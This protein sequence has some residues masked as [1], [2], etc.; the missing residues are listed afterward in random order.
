MDA[1]APTRLARSVGRSA[2]IVVDTNELW[3]FAESLR[4]AHRDLEASPT[5]ARLDAGDT[6]GRLPDAVSDFITK[7]EGP[8]EEMV[9]QLQSAYEMIVCAAQAWDD[10]ENCLVQ[11]LTG[12]ND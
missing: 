3:Q 11:A 5:Y 2:R 6:R 4:L 1:D 10:T 9:Q 12:E 7:N 8:R